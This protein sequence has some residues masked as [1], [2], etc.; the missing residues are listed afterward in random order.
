MLIYTLM[1]A[2]A[3]GVDKR[4]SLHLSPNLEALSFGL[5]VYQRLIVVLTTSPIRTPSGLNLRLDFQTLSLIVYRRFI[6]VHGD[7]FGFCL[8]SDVHSLVSIEF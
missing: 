8:D 6:V 2:T 3:T 7:A 4:P 5:A 1:T